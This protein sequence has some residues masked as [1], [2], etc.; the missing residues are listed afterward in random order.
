MVNNSA[1]SITRAAS[2]Q[3]YY[4]ILF[5]VDRDRVDDAF[6]TYAYFR[7]VD[8][9]LD[10]VSGTG[11]L[12]NEAEKSERRSF[13]KRQQSLLERCYRNETPQDVNVQEKMLV[14]LIRHDREKDSGLGIYLRNMMLVMDFDVQRRGRLISQAELD[15]Y[16]RWLAIAV[17][18]A[19]H[20][21]IGHNEFAPRDET[22]YLAVTAAH[23]VHMLRDTYDD[24]QAGYYNVPREMLEANHIGPE[25]VRSAAYRAWVGSRVQQ[26]RELFA[27]GESYFRRSR[28]ARH[29]LTGFAY[30]ARFE[31][32]LD[33][34]ER[35]GFI[36]RPEYQDRKSIGN[37][38]RMIW[39]SLLSMLGLRGK[40]NLS[41]P[42]LSQPQGES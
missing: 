38:M 9:L 4:T 20:Y 27:S 33:T 13:L 40:K 24:V 29:R 18:E 25:D 30:T 19:I 23:I 32:L 8:D 34:F 12:P 37:G 35:E 5:L 7:W 36:L 2:K 15:D 22:R 17:T 11:A 10:A 3:S 14:D 39:F 28:S 31:L 41:R 6:R 1:A 26:A 42:A 16:T 21:F